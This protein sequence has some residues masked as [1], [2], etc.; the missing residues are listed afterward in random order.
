MSEE[1]DQPTGIIVSGALGRMGQA[2][3]R[4]AAA[5]PAYRVIGALE[6][7]ERIAAAD[8]HTIVANRRF[9]L[10]PDLPEVAAPA[11]TVLVEFTSPE[12]TIVHAMQA[13][14]LGIPMVIGTTGLTADDEAGLAQAAQRIAV[15]RSANMSL[16]VN[17]LLDVVR[18]LAAA[19]PDYDI[20]VVEMHHRRKKD[21][22]SGTAL[23]LARAAAQGIGTD[24]TDAAVHGREGIVG[25]RPAGQ[26]GMHAVRG[27][28][29]VGDHTVHFAA[30]GE[31]IEVTHRA[32]SRDTFAAGALKAAQ[33]LSRR[34]PG[35][36][37]MKDVL[38][39][40]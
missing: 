19:L 15:L 26:I 7:A 24:L 32:T 35:A 11:G 34:K 8:G 6:T 25:E 16:G 3:L 28:D 22:P 17:M 21:A 27:G 10:Y 37:S 2:I 40:A 9:T 20:E 5:D 4:L 30:E 14:K 39:I 33:W 23:A 31:R 38:G 13:A 29:V 18:R 12:A 1:L 36:Y